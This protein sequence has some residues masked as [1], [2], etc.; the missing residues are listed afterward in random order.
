MTIK[1]IKKLYWFKITIVKIEKM[2]TT[3][4]YIS[5]SNKLYNN[6]FYCN[7]KYDDKK[8]EICTFLWVCILFRSNLFTSN[9]FIV[10][11]ANFCSFTNRCEYRSRIFFMSVRWNS[12]NKW[13]KGSLIL[14][15]YSG[16]PQQ[17]LQNSPFVYG[18][19]PK[20]LETLSSFWFF[21]SSRQF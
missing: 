3:S 19:R 1:K 4:V 13:L 14:W 17:F 5:P 6:R 21:Q 8:K 15:E 10:Y 18:V 2:M 11:L 12:N 9:Q 16:P 7:S 20:F